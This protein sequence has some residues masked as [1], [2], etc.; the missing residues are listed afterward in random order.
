MYMYMYMCVYIYIYIY[1]DTNIYNSHIG[2]IDTNIYNSHIAEENLHVQKVD[3]N[4]ES[5][6]ENVLGNL[7]Y[8][9]I[10]QSF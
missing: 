6:H 7:V 9:S 8:S 4:K 1:I 10:H 3:P 5:P 2:D